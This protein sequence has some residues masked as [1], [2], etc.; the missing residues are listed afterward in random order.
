MGDVGDV[1]ASQYSFIKLIHELVKLL[2]FLDFN[3]PSS[4][5]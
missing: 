5:Q 2:Q 3:V 1:E 4:T